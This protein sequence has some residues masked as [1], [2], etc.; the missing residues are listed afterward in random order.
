MPIPAEAGRNAPTSAV[1]GFFGQ[2]RNI[3]R[4]LPLS[5]TEPSHEAHGGPRRT[6][7][8]TQR[9]RSHA[10]PT[11]ATRPAAPPAA[12]RRQS[13]TPEELAHRRVR[14]RLLRYILDSSLPAKQL[15][16]DQDNHVI[17]CERNNLVFVFNFHPEK[18]IPDYRFKVD[19]AGKYAIISNSDHKDF[20]GFGRVDDEMSYPTV[21]LFGEHFLSIYVPSRTSLVLRKK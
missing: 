21:T 14:R 12:P 4:P 11:L 20:G 1:S 3:P 7:V 2:S 16:M 19:H 6:A 17:V 9:S 10:P 15:N 18:S 8:F 13:L 5:Q